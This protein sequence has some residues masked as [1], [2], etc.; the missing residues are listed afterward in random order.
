VGGDIH[1]C[2]NSEC[3]GEAGEGSARGAWGSCSTL[4]G[5]KNE[6][7]V[8]EDSGEADPAGTVTPVAF[9][10]ISPVVTS[11]PT[12]PLLVGSRASSNIRLPSTCA[13]S[14]LSLPKPRSDRDLGNCLKTGEL[15][16]A[17]AGRGPRVSEHSTLRPTS[18]E[19][20]RHLNSLTV[21]GGLFPHHAKRL[22]AQASR[23]S[24]RLAQIKCSGPALA[25]PTCGEKGR[26][27]ENHNHQ[28][29]DRRAMDLA[30]SPCCALG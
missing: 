2:D 8:A 13:D 23:D 24:S 18:V 26:N 10:M 20:P 9:A 19:R 1:P 21:S 12:S 3:S 30:R 6:E 28:Y 22:L 15:C 25:V 7:L 27:A 14:A 17:R 29:S 16:F 4:A 5:G 11:Q